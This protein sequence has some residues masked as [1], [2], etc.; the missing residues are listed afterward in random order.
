[1]F[2]TRQIHGLRA[3]ALAWF[4][5]FAFSQVCLAEH[6]LRTFRSVKGD[7]IEARLVGEADGKIVLEGKDKKRLSIFY[8]DL[9]RP[10]QSYCVAALGRRI[11]NHRE[12]GVDKGGRLY[13]YSYPSLG[14]GAGIGSAAIGAGVGTAGIGAGIGQA[15][16]DGSSGPAL[17]GTGTYA[18]PTGT[19]PSGPDQDDDGIPDALERIFRTNPTKSDT[20]R[21]GFTDAAEVKGLSNPSDP[22]SIPGR[23]APSGEADVDGDGLPAS[24]ERAFGTS[25]L[26]AD[27]DA[28][29][30]SDAQELSSLTNPNDPQSNPGA[31]GAVNPALPAHLRS[32]DGVGGLVHGTG[33]GGVAGL[34]VGMVEQPPSLGNGCEYCDDKGCARCANKHPPGCGCG[35]HGA[36]SSSS[37]ERRSRNDLPAGGNPYVLMH[38][39]GGDS[40]LGISKALKEMRDT[41]MK[42]ALL[43]YYLNDERLYDKRVQVVDGKGERTLQFFTDATKKDNVLAF[44]FQDEAQPD[45]HL[46]NFNKRPEEKYLEDLNALTRGLSGYGGLYRGVMFQVDRGKTYAK[47]FVEFVECAWRGEG[48][49]AEANLKKYYWEENRRH[50]KNHD[51]VVFSDAYHVKDDADP[52]YYM[53]LI[54]EASRKVG[55]DLQQHVLGSE[56]RNGHGGHGYNVR[57]SSIGGVGGPDRVGLGGRGGLARGDRDSIGGDDDVRV[58][59]DLGALDRALEEELVV[60][61]D[62]D[63]LVVAERYD[64]DAVADRDFRGLDLDRRRAGAGVGFDTGAGDFSVPAVGSL[65]TDL[66]PSDGTGTFSAI[67]EDAPSV[68]RAVDSNRIAVGGSRAK[69]GNVGRGEL[70]DDLGGANE[71]TREDQLILDDLANDGFVTTLRVDKFSLDRKSREESA[72]PAKPNRSSKGHPPPGKRRSMELAEQALANVAFN[73]PKKVPFGEPSYIQFVLDPRLDK[74]EIVKRIKEKGPVATAR[75]KI[76]REMEVTLTGAEFEVTPI[77]AEK[78]MIALDD[79]TEWKWSI[80]PRKPG[81]HRV[82]LV[83]NAIIR[84]DGVEMK[85][86]K[87]FDRYIE[88]EVTGFQQTVIFMQDNW[89]WLAL[90]FVP[91]VFLGPVRSSKFWRNRK[92]GKAMAMVK[93]DENREIDVFVSYSSKDR[94]VVLPL[95]ESLQGYGYNVWVDHGGLH[96]ASEWSEQIVSAIEDT[97]A[98]LLISSTHSFDSHNVVKETSLASERRKQVI[99][100]FI[101]D[102]EVPQSLQ[103][104]LAGLQRVNYSEHD[105]N[106]GIRRIVD[107]LNKLGVTGSEQAD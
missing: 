49:L 89:P 59:V 63:S 1:M 61:A 22:R 8:T 65:P 101:E 107:A 55:V 71:G 47:S 64:V 30:F 9:S 38:V 32:S 12:I 25:P 60:I 11:S 6:V 79:T 20:D 19:A 74:K 103:Y 69:L 56:D 51:G 76:T 31:H 21:D 102:A 10:D 52:Q 37:T 72:D 92:A 75:I 16:F 42:K 41:I 54:L 82:H 84:V 90:G 36:L 95:V 44:V 83:V 15:V 58:D 73:T 106:D 23:A 17:G 13:A 78:Q 48:Y 53:D 100:V 29:G 85:R 5:F 98:F 62:D 34:S 7:A 86:S 33:A 43:P 45:Y 57:G 77:M 105:H 18:P 104:Q 91:L 3:I 80:L 97:T 28:D 93:H 94:A 24:M 46:P 68:E 87:S 81:K 14:V 35:H 4:A 96:G 40:M 50:I 70:A 66:R 27:S 39:D 88:I 99:P 67:K 2:G 26:K